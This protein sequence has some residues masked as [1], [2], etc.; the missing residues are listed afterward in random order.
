[1]PNVT[2]DTE[3]TGSVTSLSNISADTLGEGVVL[4]VSDTLGQKTGTDEE[5]ESRRTHQEPV[6]RG[7]G[8]GAVDDVTDDETTDE[9]DD[10]RD[11]DSFGLCVHGDTTDEDDSLE[12]LTKDGDERK[13]E[14]S[15]LSRAGLLVFGIELALGRLLESSCE[16]QAPLDTGAVHL[17]ESNTHNVDD[18]R[19]NEREDTLPDLLRLG[20]QVTDRSVELSISDGP[21]GMKS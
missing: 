15:P 7:G 11:G 8:T 19:G 9:T 13:D 1:M 16:L 2:A 18:D 10:D 3:G 21:N 17:E 4:E 14:E 5:E 6:K 12:T 20:P